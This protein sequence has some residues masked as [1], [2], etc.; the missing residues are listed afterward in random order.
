[1]TDTDPHRPPPA[2]VGTDAAAVQRMYDRRFPEQDRA[3]K[4]AI[5]QVVVEHGLQKWVP[6]GATVLDVGCGYG[7]F[8]NHVRCA[9][10]IGVDM[11]PDSAAALDRG[12]EFHPGD[13]RDLSFLG[14]GSV[15]VVFTS[16]LLEHLPSK[17]EVERLLREAHRVLRPGGHLIALG[18][19]AR[20]VPGAYWDFWDHHVPITDRSLVEVLETLGFRTVDCIGQWLPYTTRSSLPQAPWLVRLYLRLPF[21]W[22]GLGSQF[23]VRVQKPA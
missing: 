16:N 1:M 3:R 20:I 22:R 17:A 5:W 8:L 4:A 14:D 21:L 7:E 10:R 12:V 15:D 23:L 9:R 11:N 13:V 19:N 6:H 2:P 18:P